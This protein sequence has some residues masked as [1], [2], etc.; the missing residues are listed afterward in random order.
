MPTLKQAGS[1][2]CRD[3]RE[4]DAA[5][6]RWAELAREDDG[7]DEEAGGADRRWL[8]R[9]GSIPARPRRSRPHRHGVTD[10]RS[11][12]PPRVLGGLAGGIPLFVAANHS[13]WSVDSHWDAEP[14]D[15]P[16]YAASLRRSLGLIA[17]IVLSMSATVFFVS[18]A[19]PKRYEATARMVMDDRA[20]GTEPADVE[21]V[22]RRL[23]TV[24]ALVDDERRAG[25]GCRAPFRRHGR[26]ARGQGERKRRSGR[27]HRRRARCG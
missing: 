26:V 12:R 15:V 7:G 13:G 18:N 8:R 4:R 20:G 23:A 5:P 3:R 2:E 10:R 22:G 16:R 27:Q 21:A 9:R 19:L 14:V 25:S 17:A 11:Y 6:A 24:R 1:Q